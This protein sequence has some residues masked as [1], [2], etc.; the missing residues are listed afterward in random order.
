MDEEDDVDG[1]HQGDPL[2]YVDE[3]LVVMGVELL[4]IL[5]QL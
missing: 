5:A 4:H 3:L 1:A 2:H